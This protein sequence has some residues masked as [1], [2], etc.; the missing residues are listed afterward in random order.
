MIQYTKSKTPSKAI[1]NVLLRK[2]LICQLLVSFNFEVW[3]KNSAL[4]IIFIFW[5]I[6]LRIIKVIFYF[7]FL[8]NF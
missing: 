2:N 3:S 4:V 8:A 5:K 7:E 1:E 6:F